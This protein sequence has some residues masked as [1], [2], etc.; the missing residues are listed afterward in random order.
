MARRFAGV[1]LTALLLCGCVTTMSPTDAQTVGSEPFNVGDAQRA[2]SA[3]YESGRYA[4]DLDAV[5]SEVRRW[6]RE[7]A[8]QHAR[9]AIVLDIDETSVSNWLAMKA[10]GFGY[11][12]AGD[13]NRLPQG[14][15]GWLAWEESERAPAIP[16]A[17]A[18][19]REAHSLGV[20]VFFVTGRYED[21]RHATEANL[22]AAGYDNWRGLILRPVHSHTESAMQY[23]A[24]AR[25][26][27]E[28][29]GYRIIAN[30]GD[31]P[32]DLDGGHAERTFLLPNPFYRVP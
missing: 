6:V 8:R 18:L 27:I 30:I 14:P 3:Y 23:K 20:A 10:D 5:F 21:E 24:P 17:L 31:Q 12:R 9:P 28:A 25:A 1:F 11:I 16:G 19:V 7:H 32:S 29:E 15:C 2:A 13:C 4:Q 26:R 22:R